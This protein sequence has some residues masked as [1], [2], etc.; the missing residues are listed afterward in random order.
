MRSIFSS[1]TWK[2]SCKNREECS[3]I[4]NEAVRERG[5]LLHDNPLMG[6]WL[7][8]NRMQGRHHRHLQALQQ[9]HDVAAGRAAENPVFMLK[10]DQINIAEIK[11][12]G[13]IVIG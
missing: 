1:G 6:V 5:N 4:T 8:E 9:P 11:K 12:V 13:G 7:A 10:R 2:T 3:L